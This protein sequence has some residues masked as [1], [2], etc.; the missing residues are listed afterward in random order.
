[1]PPAV[2]SI[3]RLSHTIAS[4]RYIIL[5]CIVFMPL[6]A[7]ANPAR[8]KA[9]EQACIARCPRPKLTWRAGESEE[10]WRKRMDERRAYDACYM[11]C[12]RQ[13]MEHYKYGSPNG[14]DRIP[15]R[16]GPP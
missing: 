16:P 11:E 4:M 8:W 15:R 3:P 2:F 13:Y 9:E 14:Y 5:L 1:M 12:A 6:C 7:Q 10:M